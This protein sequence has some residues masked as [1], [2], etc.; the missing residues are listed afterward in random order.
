MMILM[1][2]L[3]Q[4]FSDLPQLCLWLVL[5]S[6]KFF[7]I[8]FINLSPSYLWPRRWLHATPHGK[9]WTTKY[10]PLIIHPQSTM[11]S[12]QNFQTSARSE[13]SNDANRR[14]PVGAIV[15]ELGEFDSR[16]SVGAARSARDG[17]VGCECIFGGLC[18]MVVHYTREASADRILWLGV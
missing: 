16:D 17:T 2:D 11:H 7:R 15:L 8:R 4:I 5:S 13:E 18:A 12:Y 10:L 3:D 6:A 1:F 9:F 14:S